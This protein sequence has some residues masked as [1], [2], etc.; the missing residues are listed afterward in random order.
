MFGNSTTTKP[1]LFINVKD[2]RGKLWYQDSQLVRFPVGSPTW[3]F[4]LEWSQLMSAGYQGLRVIPR[5]LSSWQLPAHKATS[6]RQTWPFLYT[7]QI[8]IPFQWYIGLTNIFWKQISVVIWCEIN[9]DGQTVGTW[10]W[11]RYSSHQIVSKKHWE[12]VSLEE[13]RTRKPRLV[14]V[15]SSHLAS[16]SENWQFT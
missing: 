6:I 9:F 3:V 1:P 5:N 10:V 15:I 2:S 8:A 4:E 7:S 11:D 14:I 12:G 13:W 16:N